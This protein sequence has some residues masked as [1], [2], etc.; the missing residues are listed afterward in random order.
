MPAKWDITTQT[1]APV[2]K[3]I[4]YFTHPENLPKVHPEFVKSVTIKTREG[5]TISFEQQM[6]LMRR[7][8]ISQNKMNVN[9]TENKLE[10][11]TV[12][13]DGKGSKI[14][15]NFV[16]MP[17]GTE[18]HYHAEMELGALGVFAKGPAKSTMER[19]AK[20]DAAQMDSNI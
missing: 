13:G 6:E 19:V 3:V 12:E 8:I 15:M 9:R 1:R 7:K 4:E 5:D 20:E 17:S 2:E 18:I 11:N 14:T 10:I 16:P